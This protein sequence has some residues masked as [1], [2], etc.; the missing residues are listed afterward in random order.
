MKPC[1]TLFLFFSSLCVN[2]DRTLAPLAQDNNCK[3]TILKEYL[4]SFLPD[5]FSIRQHSE[6]CT[7]NHDVLKVP[8]KFCLVLK[9]LSK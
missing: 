1:Y 9:N 2:A 4:R 6:P 3:Y 5:I 8:A 7:L